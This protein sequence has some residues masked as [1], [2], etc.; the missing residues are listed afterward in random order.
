MSQKQQDVTIQ[1]TV[2][3]INCPRT[4]AVRSV[5]SGVTDHCV[6][7]QEVGYIKM[8]ADIC[9]EGDNASVAHRTTDRGKDETLGRLLYEWKQQH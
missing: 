8:T 2:N 7:H 6:V 1:E 3:C 4:V 5:I 9:L